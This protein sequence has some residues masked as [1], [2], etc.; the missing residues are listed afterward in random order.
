M[1]VG[2][3]SLPMIAQPGKAMSRFAAMG[4]ACQNHHCKRFA[5]IFVGWLDWRLVPG[6]LRYLVRSVS[7][8]T[9]E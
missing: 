7:G 9:V 6:N 5:A 1:V 3:K 4:H 2:F 8:V